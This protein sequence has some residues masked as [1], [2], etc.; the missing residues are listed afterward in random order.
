MVRPPSVRI[1]F[2]PGP[3]ELSGLQAG[4]GLRRRK[5][6]DP[7]FTSCTSFIAA[8]TSERF[9]FDTAPVAELIHWADI[10]DGAKYES[11]EV[12]SRDGRSSHEADADH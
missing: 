12:G 9:G 2:A 1:S 4:S 10:V 5:F 6:C 11:P 8:V 3:A 7:N